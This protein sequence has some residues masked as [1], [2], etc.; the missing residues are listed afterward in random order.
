MG[1]NSRVQRIR[2][3]DHFAKYRVAQRSKTENRRNVKYEPSK[4]GGRTLKRDR[5][6]DKR[7]VKKQHGLTRRDMGAIGAGHMKAPWEEKS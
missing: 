3:V 2:K 5:A 4:K 6:K 1:L 7:W